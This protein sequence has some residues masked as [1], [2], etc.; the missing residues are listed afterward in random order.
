MQIFINT[1]SGRLRTVEVSGKETIRDVKG[2]IIMMERLND[3]LLDELR[4][5]YAGRQPSDAATLQECGIQA[6]AT[7]HLVR[8]LRGD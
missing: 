3:T 1:L 8:K 2:M 5:V 7:L 6:D 4:I